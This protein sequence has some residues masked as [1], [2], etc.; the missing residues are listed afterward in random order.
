LLHKSALHGFLWSL[1]AIFRPFLELA[2]WV[3]LDFACGYGRVLRALQAGYPEATI[4]ACDL[5][6]DAIKFCA[7]TFGAIPVKGNE[8]L[9]LIEL[10]AKYDVIWV[11][12]LFTHLPI[13]RWE[14]FLSF[15]K[16][17]MSKDG[18]L[19]FTVHG[20]TALYMMERYSLLP[21]DITD[22]MF[23][24]I[25]E[26]YFDTGY[27]FFDYTKK[28][29]DA[30]AK[31]DANHSKAFGLSFTR[32]DYVC[33]YLLGLSAFNIVSY[34]EGAWAHNHDVVAL[35]L[36]SKVV[37]DMSKKKITIKRENGICP[38]CDNKTEF[39]SEHSWLRDNYRCVSCNS[40][41][42][43]RHLTYVIEQMLPNWKELSVHE[44]SPGNRGT[45]LKLKN[46]CKNYIASYTAPKNSDRKTDSRYSLV[47][48]RMKRISERSA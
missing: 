7:D 35:S 39:I 21:K 33:R 1:Q 26:Q 17:N 44:S 23:K 15:F 36:A 11:G 13:E 14:E 19:V 9:D 16:E 31:I 40:I 3:I 45:S 24:V 10:P 46:N 41:P 20:R 32:P 29:K 42:R 18:V 30:L 2:I 47:E 25:K 12:S 37:V 5:M 4:T 22:S 6:S 48:S 43:E 38:C 28:H 34:S 8:N 27:A